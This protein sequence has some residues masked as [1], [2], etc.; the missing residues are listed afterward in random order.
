MMYGDYNGN[1]LVKVDVHG[2][3]ADEKANCFPR[4]F[5]LLNV[6]IELDFL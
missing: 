2:E 3:K 1:R 4:S 5:S 6:N